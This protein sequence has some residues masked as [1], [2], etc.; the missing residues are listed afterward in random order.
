MKRNEMGTETGTLFLDEDGIVHVT[1]LPGVE[2]TLDQAK[3]S[4]AAIWKVAEHNLRPL[5]LDMRPIRSQKREVR[6][7]YNSAE[8]S[9]HYKAVA[10]LVGSPISKMIGNI[11]IGIGK[12]PV[13]TKLFSAEAEGMEWLK[14]FLK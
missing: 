9:K 1:S 13:P 2:E 14:G 7:Y 10:V 3:A 11:F 6:G 12:L 5:L 8:A 4:V